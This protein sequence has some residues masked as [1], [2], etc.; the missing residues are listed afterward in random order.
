MSSAATISVRT[1]ALTGMW[2]RGLTSA[3]AVGSI[4]S[5]ENAKTYLDAL[6][7]RPHPHQ[8]KK[9]RNPSCMKVVR[10]GLPVTAGTNTA[11][12]GETPSGNFP[13]PKRENA[14]WLNS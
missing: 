14:A 11:S 8:G 6:S 9:I 1:V 13:A 12:H 5:N 4:L 3:K 7:T 10:Y 2:K